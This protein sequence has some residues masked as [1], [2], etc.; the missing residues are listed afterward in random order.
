V[1]EPGVTG[2][3]ASNLW[4]I[5]VEGAAD[6]W[7]GRPLDANPYSRES[8]A[9]SAAAWEQGWQEA[10]EQGHFPQERERWDAKTA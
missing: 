6:W 2:T 10:R 5:V 1:A 9:D 3:V 7:T 4:P 8:A